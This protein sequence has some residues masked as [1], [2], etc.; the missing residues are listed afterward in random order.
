MWRMPSICRWQEGRAGS[1]RR[2]ATDADG[3]WLVSATNSPT[4]SGLTGRSETIVDGIRQAEARALAGSRR[5]FG[6]DM[7]SVF[8]ERQRC[9]PLSKGIVVYTDSDHL[10]AR[11]SAELAEPL[12]RALKA[13]NRASNPVATMPRL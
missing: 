5:S 4:R 8:C 3:I 2:S 7:T 12:L 10:T 6:V 9:L 13:G 11:Y 1:S